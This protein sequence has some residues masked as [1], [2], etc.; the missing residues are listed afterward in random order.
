MKIILIDA[1][2]F[3]FYWSTTQGNKAG[4]IDGKIKFGGF[5]IFYYQTLLF[6]V[7]NI[8][9]YLGYKSSF[10]KDAPALVQ[11]FEG[12]MLHSPILIITY[13]ILKKLAPVPYNPEMLP[14]EIKRKRRVYIIGIILGLLSMIFIGIVI[15]VYLRGGRIEFF[16][17]VLQRGS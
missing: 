5:M 2:D 7:G 3:A 4:G 11:I 1:R 15:P 8:Q 13:I 12:F 6:L 16:N 9:G 10:K 17:Y 14:H